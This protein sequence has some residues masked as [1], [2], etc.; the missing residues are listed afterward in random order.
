MNRNGSIKDKHCLT[1]AKIASLERASEFEVTLHSGDASN[2]QHYERILGNAVPSSK[3]L[4]GHDVKFTLTGSIRY[5]G[6]SGESMF[7]SEIDV[8]II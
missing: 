8:A 5:N 6:Q 1:V 7:T 2:S 4:V 3:P